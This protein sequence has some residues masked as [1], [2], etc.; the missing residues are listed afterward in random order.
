MSLL[1]FPGTPY[2]FIGPDPMSNNNAAPSTTTT[3]TMDA[4]N[5]AAIQIGRVRTSD[6]G[7][8]TINTTGSSSLQWRTGT[9]TFSS[10]STTVKVGLAAVDTA[11]GPPGR[12]VN[13]SNVITFDVSRTM[14]G[15]G[16]GITANAWQTHVPDTGSMT[17]A[18]GDLVAFAVQ[19]TARGGTDSVIETFSNISL[20]R[21][22][23]LVTAF[24]GGAY[25]TQ[26]AAPNCLISFSDG[27]L[28]WFYGSNVYSNLT[29][30]S[31]QSG[32]SPNERGQLF[33]FPFPIRVRGCYG[34]LAQAAS[35]D[36]DLVLYSD[37][38]GT[39]TAQRTAS[40]DQNTIQGTGAARFEEYFSSGYDVPANTPIVLAVKPTAAANVTIYYKTLN[41]ASHRVVDVWGTSGYGVNRSSGAFAAQ[42]SNLDHYFLGLIVEAFEHPARAR[43]ALGL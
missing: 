19:M 40:I 15:G 22:R 10:T 4:D 5:E 8:H 38:L 11:N 12:A 17:I 35:A 32:S 34:W 16:G 36:V 6:G 20:T 43:Y 13:V 26:S 7:S 9:V 3:I 14:T 18:D 1:T 27:A 39:P 28:G 25:S 24:T 29:S 42:N 41:S 30:Q 2:C 33:Q 21:N 23:P 37:P 31:F